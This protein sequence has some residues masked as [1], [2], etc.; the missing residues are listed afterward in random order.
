MP[1]A[2]AEALIKVRPDMLGFEEKLKEGTKTTGGVTVPVRADTRNLTREIDTAVARDKHTSIKIPVEAKAAAGG[3]VLGGGFA[4]KA[5]KEAEGVGTKAGGGFSKG[6]AGAMS[7]IGGPESQ[8]AVAGIA[9]VGGAVYELTKMGMGLVEAQDQLALSMKNSGESYNANKAAI[10]ANNTSMAKYGVTSTQAEEALSKLEP[11][12]GSVKASIKLEADAANV[13]AAQH[14]PYT[15]ALAQV[16]KLAAGSPKLLKAMGDTMVAGSTQA[17]ANAAGMKILGDQITTTGGMAQFAAV[18]HI[19]LSRAQALVHGASKGNIKDFA[20]LGL[21][22]LPKTATAA[23]KAAEAHLLLSKYQGAA[24]LKS[25]G[26]KGELGQLKTKLEDAGATIGAKLVPMLT[27]GAAALVKFFNSGGFKNFLTDMGHVFSAIG[28]LVGWA[29]KLGIFKGVWDGMV[30]P[31]IGA[32]NAIMLVVDAVKAV[33]S[34]AKDMGKIGGVVSSV[35]HAFG[36]AGG[37]D[38]APPG[39]AWTGEKG[40]ELM[41]MHGGEKVLS[42][43][44][45]MRA[46]KLPGYA[47]GT[48]TTPSPAPAATQPY[49]QHDNSDVVA[50]LDTVIALLKRQPAAIGATVGQS[51]NGVGHV[52]VAQQTYRRSTP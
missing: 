41:K 3:S 13:A 17:K 18:H 10:D 34:A 39:W 44:Q 48:F 52:A 5:V 33:I 21:D 16:S 35:A 28:T 45:S 15:A 46:T 22:V 32:Y 26:L 25:K 7:S 4:G 20:A 24:D 27:K 23:Q 49:G 50:A 29:N 38:S 11:I 1:G 47:A 19:S 9:A 2:I 36:F 42:H 43:G 40:P 51:L 30:L 31:I 14:I 8:A 6:I 37:T 12:T